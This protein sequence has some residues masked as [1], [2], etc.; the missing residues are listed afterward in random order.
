[1]DSINDNIR[2]VIGNNIICN[3]NY[4]N[5]TFIK[6][7]EA[8]MMLNSY[9]DIVLSNSILSIAFLD[10]YKSINYKIRHQSASKNEYYTFTVLNSFD[11]FDDIKEFY[12][13]DKG[14]LIDGLLYTVDF[15][16]ENLLKKISEV[17]CLTENQ[18]EYLCD[19]APLHKEDLEKYNPKIDIDYLCDYFDKRFKELSGDYDVYDDSVIINEICGF[20]KEQSIDY[21]DEFYDITTVLTKNVFDNLDIYK[22]KTGDADLISDELVD[23][24]NNDPGEFNM[25]LTN[26]VDLDLLDSLFDVYM[27]MKELKIIKNKVKEFKKD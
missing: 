16:N 18:N 8:S 24:Y 11:T 7:I 26:E 3:N 14:L 9:N 6:K 20:L 19:L 23:L 21:Y 15:L 12:S 1:M 10:T 4:P 22:Q 25:I 5:N 2:N 13:K 17:R 27:S